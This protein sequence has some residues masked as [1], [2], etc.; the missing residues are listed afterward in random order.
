MAV[1]KNPAYFVYLNRAIDC[2]VAFKLPAAIIGLLIIVWAIAPIL[3]DRIREP[4]TSPV[5]EPPPLPE[6]YRYA[7]PRAQAAAP[8]KGSTNFKAASLPDIP[9]FSSGCST[10]RN[11]FRITG[12]IQVESAVTPCRIRMALDEGCMTLYA[13]D[14]AR[15]G[16]K[17]VGERLQ[18][19]NEVWFARGEPSATISVWYCPKDTTSDE[20][21]CA[22]RTTEDR[23]NYP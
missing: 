16:R 6:G 22:Q 8:A 10:K 21:P 9:I 20:W 19:K 5:A 11:Q 23:W 12:L 2:A 7:P 1:T 3:I 14:Y 18:I 17:C 15:L 13:R 4:E